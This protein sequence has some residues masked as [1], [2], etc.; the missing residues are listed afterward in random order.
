MKERWKLDLN[1]LYIL[2]NSKTIYALWLI[3]LMNSHSNHHQ[4]QRINDCKRQAIMLVLIWWWLLLLKTVA[5]KFCSEFN[6]LIDFNK[7]MA[8]L[9][10]VFRITSKVVQWR[11][12]R[13]LAKVLCQCLTQLERVLLCQ[14]PH[15]IRHGLL[16][17]LSN[18]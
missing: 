18:L 13:L 4:V 16:Q 5:K 9:Q 11:L 3:H 1:L 8:T 15:L 10:L 17:Q 12:C 2:S 6:L 14:V 7:V